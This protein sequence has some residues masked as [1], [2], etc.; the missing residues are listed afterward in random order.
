MIDELQE[1]IEYLEW[2]L[3]LEEKICRSCPHANDFGKDA[4]DSC[5]TKRNIN[6]LESTLQ[7]LKEGLEE[8]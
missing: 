1:H 2:Q 4:C 3:R 5:G 7:E 8:L 6:N